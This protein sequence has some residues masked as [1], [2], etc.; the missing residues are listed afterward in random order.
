MFAGHI[1]VRIAY[2]LFAQKPGEELADYTRWIGMTGPGDGTDLLR[3]NGAGENLLWAAADFE[4]FLQPRPDLART[5]ESDLEAIV[6][7]LA[8]EQWPWRIHATY[9][10]SI[11]RFLN[12]FEHVHR[13]RPIDKLHWFFDHTETASQKNLERIAK[14]CVGIAVQHRMAYQCEYFIRRYVIDEV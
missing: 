3:F 12:I 11:S 7:K 14:L 6:H 4:N 10:E 8:D 1:T 5:M 2:G 9:D 13:D